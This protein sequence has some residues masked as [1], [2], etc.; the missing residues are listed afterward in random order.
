MANVIRLILT[1]VFGLVWCWVYLRYTDGSHLVLLGS[2]LTLC[3]C[4]CRGGDQ[5]NEWS[6]DRYFAC[7]RRCLVSLWVL[8]VALILIGVLWAIIFGGGMPAGGALVRL[9]VGAVVSVYA[10]RFICCAYDS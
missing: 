2:I 5:S 3:V 10:I 8:I 7:L 9:V 4:C 6:F 1:V